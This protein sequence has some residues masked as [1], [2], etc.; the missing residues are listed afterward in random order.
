MGLHWTEKREA[1]LLLGLALERAGWSLFGYKPD[2][3]E[4]E[5]D[6]YDPATW[7]GVATK[8][9][10]TVVVEGGAWL[11]ADYKRETGLDILPPP[12]RASWHV[13]RGG[14]ILASG[15]GVFSLLRGMGSLSYSEERA[16]RERRYDELAARIERDAK[17][18]AALRDKPAPT[19]VSPVDGAPHSV[20]VDGI[21]VR[22]SAVKPG[23]AEVVFP[24]K[25]GDD[26][27]EELKRAGYRWNRFGACW[28]G[29]AE[30]LPARY[31]ALLAVPA[32]GVA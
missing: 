6:Y 5:T 30:R 18:A 22:L 28:Y 15:S 23:N 16:E 26:L 4:L 14:E 8:G 3:S 25:P 10:L 13:E 32:E 11:C 19:S 27:R 1:K 24:A 29:K 12:G 2:K 20:T 17:R 21:T 7:R 9:D 31:A